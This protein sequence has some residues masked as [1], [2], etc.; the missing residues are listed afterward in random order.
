MIKIK[1]KK[2]IINIFILIIIALIFI[3]FVQNK[4]NKSYDDILF[5]KLLGNSNIIQNSESQNNSDEKKDISFE[6]NVSYKNT[7]LK[8]VKLLETVNESE[9]ANVY[10]KIAPGTSGNFSIIL[11]SNKKSEYK[12]EFESYSKKP[13]N[14]KFKA[15]CDGKVISEEK[16]SL[17]NLA[18]DL[19]GILQKN[20]TKIIIVNWYW[21]YENNQ[22]E[23]SDKQ[24]TED[25]KTISQYRFGIYA[26]G[27]EI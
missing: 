17:E 5:L 3:F 11:K 4:K 1:K 15:F 18:T 25:S 24:D 14:L 26:Y 9:K 22:S 23:N 16:D 7:K 19:K 2:Y 20:E 8:N 21:D 6:F 27:N 13:V 12:V 10:E